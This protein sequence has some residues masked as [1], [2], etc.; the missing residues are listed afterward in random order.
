MEAFLS[1]VQSFQDLH[2]RGLSSLPARDMSADEVG[3]GCLNHT[4]NTMAA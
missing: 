3:C 4:T 1:G 2:D